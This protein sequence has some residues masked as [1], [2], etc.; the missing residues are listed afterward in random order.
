VRESGS[1]GEVSKSFFSYRG[2][3]YKSVKVH[4]G[5]LKFPLIFIPTSSSSEYVC[6]R[7]RLLQ[8]FASY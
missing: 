4:E 7:L 6:E 2:V 3:L 5:Y 8:Q 1:S